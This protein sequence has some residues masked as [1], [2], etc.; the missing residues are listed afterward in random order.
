MFLTWYL[1]TFG[2]FMRVD[3]LCEGGRRHIALS[4]Y[5]S[6]SY[7]KSYTLLGMQNTLTKTLVRHLFITYEAV[8]N[9]FMLDN[10][11][12]NTHPPSSRPQSCINSRYTNIWNPGM[13]LHLGLDT[14]AWLLDE[15]ENSLITYLNDFYTYHIM[16]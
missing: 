15:F 7:C 14:K 9:T 5:Y 1:D 12:R 2:S 16:Q 3:G 8:T 13:V 10:T 11:H 6:L 4:Y